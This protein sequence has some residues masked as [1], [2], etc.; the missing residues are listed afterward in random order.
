[1]KRALRTFVAS[2]LLTPLVVVTWLVMTESGLHWAY[3]NAYQYAQAYLPGQLKISKLEG[4][5]MGPITVSGLAY[6]HDGTQVSADQITLEWLPFALLSTTVNISR[7]HVSS[8]HIVLPQTD[9]SQSENT[10]KPLSLPDIHLPWRVALKDVVIDDF[11][12]NQHEQ[13]V[14][15]DKIRLS[16]SSLFSQ[17]DIDQLSIKSNNFNLNIQGELQ[18]ANTYPHELNVSWQ[19]RL[20]SSAVIKGNGQL[21]GSLATTYL[22]V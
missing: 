12:F 13:S 18:L 20:P 17:V 1:M 4:R 9:L 5:L 15:L 14:G 22:N 11:T 8:L 3:E 10:D 16:A 6:E 19:A 21:A 2:L 7:L